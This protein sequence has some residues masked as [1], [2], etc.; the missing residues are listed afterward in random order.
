MIYE[1]Q[2]FVRYPVDAFLI[3]K[4]F[5]QLAEKGQF[6]AFEESLDHGPFYLKHMDDKGDHIL[7]DDDFNVTGIIDWTFAR[8]VPIYEAFGPSLF[9]AEMN[10]IYGGKAGLA[11]QDKRFHKV[12]QGKSTDLAKYAG[13]PDI[14]RCLTF[15]LGM[16]LDL[17]WDEALNLFKA[18]L[19]TTTT[20]ATTATATNVSDGEIEWKKW[21]SDRMVE[22]ANDKRL[23]ELCAW[24]REEKRTKTAFKQRITPRWATCSLEGCGR[25]SVRGRSCPVCENHL[26]ASHQRPQFHSCASQAEVS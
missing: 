15:A 8:T 12:I 22:W 13:S 24:E 5:G 23:A 16:G 17:P 4:Y 6:N 9:T 19:K 3:F 2:L 14:V 26:C 18:I 11:E 20:G 10:D 21:R 1:K 7:V 25:P